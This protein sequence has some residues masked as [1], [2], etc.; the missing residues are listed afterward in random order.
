MRRPSAAVALTGGALGAVAVAATCA[1]L[2]AGC[3]A[4]TSGASGASDAAATL[5]GPARLAVSGAYIP[6]PL[7]TDMAAGY[8]TVTNSGGTAARLTSV[9][10]P[11]AAHVTLHTTVGTTMR[12]VES[13]TV[14]AGG[15]LTLGSGGDHLMLENL[16]RRPAVGDKVTLTLHFDHATPATMSVTVPVRPTTY[17]PK[18]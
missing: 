10:T 9:T 1:V 18:G 5:R 6:R 11:L 2:L 4:G 7:L 15:S 8:F 12:Q 14:P 3:G 13:F 16:V 17:T